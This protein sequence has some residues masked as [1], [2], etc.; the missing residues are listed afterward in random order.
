VSERAAATKTALAPVPGKAVEPQDLFDQF[1]RIYDSIERRAFE[2]FEGNGKVFG[3]DLED[4]FKAE[5][6]LLHPVK[7]NMTE[8]G[9]GLTVQAEVPGFT[10][11]D[12]EIRV[13]PRRLTITGRRETSEEQKEGKTIYQEHR[14]NEILRVIDLPSGVDTEKTI[15]TLKNG[16][17]EL[18]NAE[19]CKELQDQ[20]Y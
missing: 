6:E 19:E 13:E 20:T 7:I 14:S 15:A 8:T 1:D 16:V 2:I 18:H 9:P 3:H 12:I 4:W 5:S 10:G 17:L 11:R